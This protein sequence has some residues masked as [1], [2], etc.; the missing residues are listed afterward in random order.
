M[1]K[2]AFIVIT[3]IL[4]AVPSLCGATDFLPLQPDIAARI[5]ALKQ[6]VQAE[7]GTYEVGYSTAMDIP[8]EHLTGLKVPR[9]WNKSEAPSVP[10]L[11]ASVQTLPSSYDWRALNG[12]TPIKNQGNCGSC[13]AFSTVG[14]MESQILLQNGLQNGNPVVL[15]E[16][17]LVSCNLDGWN[18]NGGWFA[19][20]YHMD[21]SG[22]DNNAPGAVLASA[23]PYTGTNSSCMATYNHPYR[24]SS[25]AYVGSEEAV[26][27]I[28]AIKQ[29]IYTYGPLSAGV[30]AGPKFQAYS[31]G[32]FNTNESGTINHAIVLVGWNDNPGYWIL[33]N[34][35][36]TSW[37][38][39]GYMYIGYGISQVGYA[40][41]F[42]EYAG[43]PNPPTPPPTPPPVGN[44]PY[45][46]GVFAGVSTSNYGRKL[47]GSLWVENTGNSATAGSFPVLLYVSPDG[48]TKSSLL[49]TAT[50][51]ALI[52][53][54]YY[55]SLRI[56]DYSSTSFN[57]QY[58]IAVIDPGNVIPDSN[59]NNIF[60]SNM[61]SQKR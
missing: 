21:E 37:G 1:K 25:W 57:G 38:Q 13:W 59:T 46:T 33:R 20:D 41:N 5:E 61:I 55:V 28:D 19:H 3:A 36:G 39:A 26:P 49:G 47:S 24:L 48:T 50:I 23:D 9:G 29:A 22:Q 12:V 30:Y 16:Q 7:G 45:L 32:V 17:Y 42:I 40:A 51:S 44:K 8:L 10:M 43:T 34:S 27:T 11:G 52:P 60:V 2:F 14:P 31:S 4:L 56:R 58:L 6:Q 53:P 15:S 54:N 35:W 18:C